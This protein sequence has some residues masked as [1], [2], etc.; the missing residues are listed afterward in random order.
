MVKRGLLVLLI[1]VSLTLPVLAQDSLTRPEKI[2][3]F[4]YLYQILADNY[5]HF[6][7]KERQTGINWLDN[8]EEYLEE[9]KDTQGLLD[10]YQTLN[11]ILGELKNGHTHI[12]Q[13]KLFYSYRTWQIFQKPGPWNEILFDK[14]VAERYSGLRNILEKDEDQIQTFWAKYM[15]GDYYVVKS[16]LSALPVGAKIRAIDNQDMDSYIRQVNT[17]GYNF[18]P[19]H[20]RLYVDLLP[21]E[22]ERVTIEYDLQG[23]KETVEVPT[24]ISREIIDHQETKVRQNKENVVTSIIKEGSI[25]Y[26]KVRS[27][28]WPNIKADRD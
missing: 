4:E 15:A 11:Q 19:I 10:Y 5:P 26:L 28:D 16:Y 14:E 2:E 17:G 1:L 6:W 23:E 27:F 24:Q 18:D 25:A 12:L 3:E 9:I 7:I 22:K 21:L 20:D 13:P 8:K